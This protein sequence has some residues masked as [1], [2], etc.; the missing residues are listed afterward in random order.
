MR[1]TVFKFFTMVILA[2][3]FHMQG[4]A[5]SKIKRVD[6]ELAQEKFQV[7]MAIET[8]SGEF[9]DL[10][11]ISNVKKTKGNIQ[12]IRN[13]RDIK[14]RNGEVIDANSIR[15]LFVT[16]KESARKPTKGIFKAPADE[17]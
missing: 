17:E 10:S 11:E 2:M 9:Y 13:N 6:V 8:Y 15:Y 4:Y 1:T 7:A 12:D 5:K 3:T 16:T 14:L